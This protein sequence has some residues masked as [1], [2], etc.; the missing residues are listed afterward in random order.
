MKSIEV[1]KRAIIRMSTCRHFWYIDPPNGP[2]S[3]GVCKQC[4]A[5]M[6]FF[7]SLPQALAGVR[8]GKTGFRIDLRNE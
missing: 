6:D 2:S 5:K 7:N 1:K 4:G 3:I 8:P